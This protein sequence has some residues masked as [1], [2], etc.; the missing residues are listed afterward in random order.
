MELGG[1][2]DKK[3]AAGLLSLVFVGLAAPTWTSYQHD[4]KIMAGFRQQVNQDMTPRIMTLKTDGVT[5]RGYLNQGAAM[6]AVNIGFY[7]MPTKALLIAQS[8][9]AACWY[10]SLQVVEGQEKLP[11]WQK[12]FGGTEYER[13]FLNQGFSSLWNTCSPMNSPK[14]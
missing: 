1:I 7:N 11:F 5:R 4:Q 10:T 14:P 2:F 8:D 13:M 3:R 9:Q 6:P 12:I